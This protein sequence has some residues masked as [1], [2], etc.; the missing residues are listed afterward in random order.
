[1]QQPSELPT[2]LPTA[3]DNTPAPT[4]ASPRNTPSP[5]ETSTGNNNLEASFDMSLGAPRCD[6]FASSCS[7]VDLLNGRG[8]I[9]NGAETNGPNTLDMCADGDAGEYHI[10]QSLDKIVVKS[11][12]MDGSDSN[13]I[14]TEG[15]LATITATVYPVSDPSGTLSY[16][17]ADFYY[18]A[19]TSSPVWIYIGTESPDPTIKTAQE[20]SMSYTLPK[21]MHQAVRVNFRFLGDR[22]AN[23]GCS[24][25]PYDDTDDIVFAV[26]ENADITASPIDNTTRPTKKPERKY[27]IHAKH[28]TQ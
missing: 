8:S 2:Y 14:M 11:S 28:Y 27:N 26:K 10:D 21:G 1:M 18:A 6:T 9:I 3:G 15:G 16:D 7:S 19:D 20:L 13:E 23:A 17:Y 4:M 12:N 24:G 25:G 22:G 5:T